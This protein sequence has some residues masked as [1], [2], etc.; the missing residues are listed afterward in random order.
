L[1]TNQLSQT[2]KWDE[3]RLQLDNNRLAQTND[4]LKTLT[5]RNPEESA[6][7]YSRIVHGCCDVP[8]TGGCGCHAGKQ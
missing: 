1:E 2:Q 7:A 3:E 6:R 5:D 8:Q 4:L